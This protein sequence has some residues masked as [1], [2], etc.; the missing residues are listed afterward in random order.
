MYV[1]EIEFVI[2]NLPTKKTPDLD[3]CIDIFYNVFE[4]EI[5]P[6][7]YKLKKQ[8]GG[9]IYHLLFMRPV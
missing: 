6:I 4:E 8:G 7:P 2:K 3:G 9:S 1:K 5:I